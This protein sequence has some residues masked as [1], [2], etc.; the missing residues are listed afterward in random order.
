MG[1]AECKLTQRKVSLSGMVQSVS[2]KID[3]AGFRL[4]DLQRPH[5]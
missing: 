1:S 2:V 3:Y 4:P 5:V